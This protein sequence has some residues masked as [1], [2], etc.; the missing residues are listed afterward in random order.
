M[1]RDIIKYVE[2]NL[3][4]HEGGGFYSAEDADPY[5]YDGA[6]HKLGEVLFRSMIIKL[7]F[8]EVKYKL[9]MK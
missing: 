2:Q 3:R 4:D 8:K 1:A 7:L 9:I 6:K 5:P